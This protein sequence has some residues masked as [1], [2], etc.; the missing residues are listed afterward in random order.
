MA[1]FCAAAVGSLFSV[2]LLGRPKRVT[3]ANRV[4]L[5][6]QKAQRRDDYR[7]RIPIEGKFGQGKQGYRLNYIRAKRADTSVAWINSLFLVMN[8][9]VLLK[10][11]FARWKSVILV[12]LS[13]V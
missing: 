8:L 6:Q 12:A 3:E 9:M 13:W 10:R 7:Q 5:K 2:S 11:F 1:D 4:E